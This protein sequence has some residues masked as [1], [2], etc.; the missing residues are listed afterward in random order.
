MVILD[1]EVVVMSHSQI[2]G[3]IEV[4]IEAESFYFKF[5]MDISGISGTSTINFML[6][7]RKKSKCADSIY[8]SNYTLYLRWFVN[9]QSGSVIAS[10]QCT[11]I[12]QTP[13]S[14]THQ[15]KCQHYT[16][17]NDI[18]AI[19]KTKNND[20]WMRM[21]STESQ[22]FLRHQPVEISMLNLNWNTY[23]EKHIFLY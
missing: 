13:H 21:W 18:C 15:K 20:L 11:F 19:V 17:H 7:L 22:K 3:Q 4:V 6:F 12:I 9:Y 2:R 8:S 5:G 10:A 23:Y 16:Y 14:P 1:R